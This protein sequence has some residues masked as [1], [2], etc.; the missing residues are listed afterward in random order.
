M[1]LKDF[2]KGE[3]GKITLDDSIEVEDEFNEDFQQ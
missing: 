1:I 2:R 3:L